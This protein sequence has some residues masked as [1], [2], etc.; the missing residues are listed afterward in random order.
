V[1]PGGCVGLGHKL[2]PAVN[3]L[4]DPAGLVDD[5]RVEP[6][7]PLHGLLVH[8]DRVVE[9][10]ARHRVMLKHVDVLVVAAQYE[11]QMLR[12]KLP[13]LVYL[14]RDQAAL[15]LI[16]L[17]PGAVQDIALDIALD[18]L[19]LFGTTNESIWR[20]IAERRVGIVQSKRSSQS[21]PVAGA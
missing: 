4:E 5:L 8:H 12:V 11:R 14:V 6:Q 10:V 16:V 2:I 18:S 17:G 7:V 9:H 1:L 15:E 3:V 20:V 13:R 19:R 21:T